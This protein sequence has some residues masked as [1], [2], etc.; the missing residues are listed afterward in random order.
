MNDDMKEI[1]RMRNGEDVRV[2]DEGKEVKSGKG[3]IGS[4]KYIGAGRNIGSGRYVGSGR[5]IGIDRYIR[6]DNGV[7]IPPIGYGT[8][9]TPDGNVAIEAVKQALA[10]GYRLIDAAAYDNEESVGIGIAQSGIDRSDIFVTSK[11]WNTERGYDTTMRAFDKSCKDLGLEYLDLYLI[12]WPASENQFANWRGINADTWRAMET[13]YKE[14]RIRSI[15][16]SNF[17]PHH[18]DALAKSAEI[19]P[20]VNQ[21]EFHPGFMQKE[22]VE[23][24]Q[25]HDI[26]VEAWS[27]LGRRRLF[28]NKTLQSMA[29]KYGKSIAQICLRWALQ[30]DVIPLPK[31]VTPERI[32]EN[33]DVFDF[34]ISEDDML[35]IDGMGTVGGSGLDPDHIVF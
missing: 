9:Q 13:L 19:A 33:L 31:S 20:M 32:K 14:G 30:H 17:M 4:G 25:A 24:C 6:L 2:F 23:Y 34:S 8:W 28:G 21:I 7:M 29:D 27:P 1:E 15:G 5:N 35:K 11:V 3:Y 18:L 10:D 22:C 12:H 16:V 26:Q